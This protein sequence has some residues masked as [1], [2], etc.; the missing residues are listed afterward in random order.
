MIKVVSFDI[1][2]TL[3]KVSQEDSVLMK[4]SAISV[5]NADVLKNAYVEHFLKKNIT[6]EQFCDKTNI[7][8]VEDVFDV[9][10]TYYISKSLPLIYDDVLPTL[11]KIK[12]KNLLMI[13]ISNKS[14]KNPFC[15]KSYRLESWFYKEIYSYDAGYTKPD[16]NIFR[17]AEQHIRVKPNEILQKVNI[18]GV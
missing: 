17:Y 1:G 5:V 14:Y 11:S 12:K 2:G 10:S 18:I 3:V 6:I 15:L 7:A 13:T 9:V 16:I 4:L 8:K